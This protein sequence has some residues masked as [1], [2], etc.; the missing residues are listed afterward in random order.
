MSRKFLI[1]AALLLAGT[2]ASL[3]QGYGYYGGYNSAPNGY[4]NGYYDAAPGYGGNGY[5]DST[6]GYGGN[7][8]YDYAPGYSGYGYS[9]R[10]FNNDTTRGGPG[11]RVQA[12]SGM[13]IGA[14]R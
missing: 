11:P 1:A 14:E 10:V 8:Y 3:A 4:G 6:P 13:G 2:S 5:Y 9:G 12:G 7:G